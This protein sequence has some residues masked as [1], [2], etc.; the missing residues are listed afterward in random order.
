MAATSRPTRRFLIVLIGTLAVALAGLAAQGGRGPAGPGGGAGVGRAG[1]RGARDPNGQVLETGTGSISGVVT[2]AGSGT[3][4]RRAQVILGGGGRGGRTAMT[5]EEGRFSF[6]ALPAGRFTL[7]VV[8]PG[9]SSM[10]YGAKKPGRQGTPIQLAD[11]QSLSN[12]DVTLPKGGVITGVVVDEYGDPSPNTAVRAYRYVMQNGESTLQMTQQSQTDDRGVY[13]IFQLLPGDYLVGAVPRNAGVTDMARQIQSQLEPLLQQVQA[14]GGVG[15]VLAGG[16]GAIGSLMAS[17]RGQQLMEQV[18]VLQQQLAEQPEQNTAYAPVY[19]PGTTTFSQ[20][21]RITLDAGQERGGIDFRLQLVP[22]ARVSGRITGPDPAM[23]PG[24]QVTLQPARQPG[25]SSLPAGLGMSGARVMPDGSFSFQ[26]VTPGQYRLIAR[27]PVRQPEPAADSQANAGNQA[28]PGRGG[29]GFGRGGFGGGPVQMLWAS[30]D[31]A[32]DGHDVTDLALTLQPG[33][34]L[35]GRVVFAG[36]S[37]QPPSDLSTVRITLAPLDGGVFSPEETDASGNFTV[38]GISPGRYSLRA[39]I[40]GPGRGGPFGGAFGGPRG[41]GGG[42]QGASA[43][44]LKSAMLN[45]ID[46]LDF[47]L[48]V[49]PGTNLAGALLTFT[50]QTQSIGGTVQD[51]MGRPTADYTIILFPAD[52]RF[53]VPQSR[54]ILSTRPSTDGSFSFRNF[55]AGTYRLTA[56]TDAEPGEWYDPAFLAQVVPASMVVTI[57]EGENKTQDIR[58]AR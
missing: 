42:G 22:T 21:S 36:T 37:S 19:Y 7:N 20:A 40:G 31:V 41:N 13:R 9:Y 51:A 3:P 45:G 49:E 11:G 28:G 33:L 54:R 6:I 56:V 29:R 46:L 34:T 44:T 24:T 32:V 8:K 57:G 38:S 53:W 25:G 14:A 50:D 10:A 30:T 15:A 35:S 5:N 52:N 26:S 12:A 18:Q 55:P 47:P 1:G 23:P 58:L 43:W 2:L 48:E 39:S 27:A 17:G 4:V 16:G